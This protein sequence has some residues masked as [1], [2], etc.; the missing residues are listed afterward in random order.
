MMRA[1]RASRGRRTVGAVVAGLSLAAS[2]AQA[3]FYDYSG[4]VHTAPTDLFPIDVGTALLDLGFTNTLYVG[5]GALGSFSALAGAQLSVGGLSLGDG[6]TG[7]GSAVVSGAQVRIGGADQVNRVQV[8]NWGNGSL[9]VSNGGLVDA[10]VN[11]AACSAAGAWCRNYI[12]NAAGSDATLTVTGAGSEM[13]TLRSF[14]VGGVSVFTQ[15]AD[16]LDFGTPGGTT[17]GT[18]NVLAGGTLRT[19]GASLGV[20]PGGG[21]PLGTEKSFATALIDGVGSQWIVTRNSVDGSTAFMGL[22]THANA[23]ADVTVSGGGLLR[24][25]GAGSYGPNDGIA[26]G[27]YGKAM[28]TITGTGSRLEVAGVSPFINVGVNAGTSDGTLQILDGASASSLFMNV[29]RDGGKGTLLID[30]AGSQLTLSGV[31]DPVSPGAA[32]GNVGRNGGTGVATLRNGGRWLI[33]DGGLDSRPGNTNPGFYVGRGAG[34]DGTLTI[35]GTGSILEVVSTSIGPGVGEPDNFNPFAAFG[36]DSGSVGDLTV[37]AG[38]RLVMTGQALSTVADSRSTVLNIG[39]FSDTALG[40]TGTATLTGLG[41]QLRVQGIDGLVAV[42]R[43]GTGTLTIKDQGLLA[44]TI[45]N[46]GRGE[47]G[48]GTLRMDH[49]FMELSGQQTGNSLSGAGMAVGSRGGTGVAHIGN[50]SVVTITN[51]G[52]SGAGLN[53]GGTPVNPLGTGR[54]NVSG[55]SQIHVIAQPGLAR[56]RIGHDGDGAATFSGGS[57][58]DAAGGDVIIAGEPGSKGRLTLND[59]SVLNADYVG[60]GSRRGGIDG[61]E[62]KLYVNASTVNATTVEIGSFSKLGGNDGLIN[63]FVINR[64]TL[65]PGNSP[66]RVVI[67]GG[68]RNDEGSTIVLDIEDDGAGGYRFDEIVLTQ[69]SSYAFGSVTVQFSFL[70]ATDPVAAAESGALAMDTFLR[71]TDGSNE[72]GLSSTFGAGETW[73]TVLAD[74]SFVAKSNAYDVTSLVLN[75]DGSGTFTVAAVPVPEPGAWLLHLLGLAVLAGVVRRR[76]LGA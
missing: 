44:T 13:R 73:N 58:L 26:V 50:G 70:G 35:T 45:V 3:Q 59:G 65:S 42:G 71:V 32:F 29:G 19:E 47:S 9:L 15:A 72:A 36:R 41:S 54:L 12:G 53:V 74:A 22:A 10:T 11:G 38:G 14:T 60:V 69:G 55:G 5:F 43:N 49:G 67:N 2:A 64:G 37:K 28:L 48:D 27:Q 63:A 40:G 61:G 56:V 7:N 17:H 6:G 51:P 76:E 31:G 30:G 21:S 33:T 8:G 46:I 16:G 57:V 68:I 39:G 23:T 20:G 34:S 24:I 52:S 4:S 66:G 1:A 18:V 62:G 25:D 75:L